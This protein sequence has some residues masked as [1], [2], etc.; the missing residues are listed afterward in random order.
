MKKEKIDNT[1]KQPFQITDAIWNRVQPFLADCPKVHVGNPEK[2]RLFLS[3][4]LWIA[5]EGTT[6]ST[7]PDRYGNWKSISQ[8]FRHWCNA[9]V[10]ESLQAYFQADIE[11][12]N[13][14]DALYTS[15]L[16]A[17]TLK[18]RIKKSLKSQG[19][20]V[21]GNQ[22]SLPN[23]LD[24]PKIRDLHA[25]AVHRKIEERKK[26]L[27]KHEPFL[28]K[29]F[30]FGEEVVPDK[31]NPK[32]V[33]VHSGSKEELLFRYASLHWSIPVSS[34]YGRR[35]RFLVVDQHTNKLMGL[36]GLGD[37]VFSLGHRDQ[38]VGW[39]KED[40]NERLHHVVDAFVLGAVPPY[41]FLIGG[42]LI[43]L[44]TTSNE[45]RE[46]FKN[47]YKGRISVIRE[48]ENAGEIA[49]IT[50]TSAL[51][52]SSLYNRL[53]CAEPNLSAQPSVPMERL[54]KR[55]VF[56]RV[57][58]TQGFG[59][60]HFSNGIYGALT[61]YAKSNA[62]ATASHE[63]WGTGF[64]NRQ[65]VV[66]KALANLELPKSWLNHGI[67]REIYVAPLAE[68]TCAFLCGNDSELNYY[69]QPASELFKWYR[70]RWLLDR[71]KRDERY[72]EWK[73]EKWKLW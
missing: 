45:V 49:L 8:R 30:A 23:N 52:R 32:L 37:P 42:K 41:S 46:I 11:I 54:E 13:I 19:F 59:E 55:L 56:E 26:G 40:R 43:A 20:K 38:W 15:T 70:E 57:G 1:Q 3:A 68:N 67:K 34:G 6:W 17:K 60:F 61:N 50:T 65:E 24:K 16:Y 35:L 62:E 69:D 27:V 36:F 12:S 48:R 21:K 63:S 28:L 71:S 64:R 39:N 14:L 5:G 72:K 4:V 33:E 44:L 31:V 53:K 66:Q 25:Q 58:H 29:Q 73:P 9:G 51:E 18:T 47:K 2:C 7:L 10:F 22:I